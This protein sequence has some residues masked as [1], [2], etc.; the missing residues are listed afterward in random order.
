MTLTNETQA[1]IKYLKVDPPV[2]YLTVGQ[3][4]QVKAFAVYAS[5]RQVEV[6]AKAVWSMPT[7]DVGTVSDTGIVSAKNPGSAMVAARYGE[8]RAESI[9]VSIGQ[10]DEAE[11]KNNRWGRVIV[12]TATAA[13]AV[14]V[15]GAVYAHMLQGPGHTSRAPQ[16]ATANPVE[17]VGAAGEQLPAATLQ[18]GEAGGGTEQHPQEAPV[19]TGGQPN[20][21]PPSAV[22]GTTQP[23]ASL[24]APRPITREPQPLSAESAKPAERN[25]SARKQG[26]PPA[27][28]AAAKAKPTRKQVSQPT[29]PAKKMGEQTPQ[30]AAEPVAATAAA[31]APAVSALLKPVEKGGKWGYAKQ[32]NTFEQELVISY[33]YDHA[34]SFSDGLAL[35]KKDGKFGYI[36]QQGKLVIGF[37]FDY[38]APFREGAATVKMDGQLRRIDKSGEFID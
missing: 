4:A 36:D 16:T 5:G 20:V 11:Q 17:A 34:T 23:P 19:I 29:A 12:W 6:T 1:E 33:Q 13:A 27:A 31:P 2:S 18:T 9:I 32:V 30:R 28:P 8:H 25:E 14:L 10:R 22:T 7:T 26:V 21:S 37:R 15:S 24:P 35:V 38:A 3:A